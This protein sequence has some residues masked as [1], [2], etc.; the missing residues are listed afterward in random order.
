MILRNTRDEIV[1]MIICQIATISKPMCQIRAGSIVQNR[2]CNGKLS[3]SSGGCISVFWMETAHL[4][5]ELVTSSNIR[6]TEAFGA[7]VASETITSAASA[8]IKAGSSS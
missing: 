2:R 3:R 6:V 5:P 1:Y 8:A 7:R 4:L